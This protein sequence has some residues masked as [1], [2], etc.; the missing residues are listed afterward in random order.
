MYH[1]KRYMQYKVIMLSIT[2]QSFKTVEVI[3][4]FLLAKNN[5]DNNMHFC[6]ALFHTDYFSL[7]DYNY[8]QV[9]L[10][11]LRTCTCFTQFLLAR[12]SN[13]SA[14]KQWSRH[15]TLPNHIKYSDSKL[16]IMLMSCHKLIS[17]PELDGT[18][19]NFSSFVWSFSEYHEVIHTKD[20]HA[21]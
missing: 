15:S 17:M 5:T 7:I 16:T 6:T 2:L 3:I 14:S 13:E 4:I 20:T 1:I 11:N 18:M 10:T 8:L 9:V 12:V 19:L 21:C